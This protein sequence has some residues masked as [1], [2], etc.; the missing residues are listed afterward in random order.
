MALEI[1]GYE[2]LNK[3]GQGSMGSVFK[4]RQMSVDRLVAVKILHP[5]LAGNKDYL[6]RFRREAHLAARFSSIHVV[7][8]I[9]VGSAGNVHYFVMEYVE[10]KTVQADLSAGKVFGEREAL[11]IVLQVAQALRQAHRRGLVHRDVKPGNI[12]LTV[13]GVAKLADLGLARDTSDQAAVEA[14]QGSLV[15]TPYY[16]A[17]EQIEG[18]KDIDIRADL[19]ALGAT[20]Y[21]MVTGRPPFEGK[22]DEVLD[23]HLEQDVPHPDRINQTLSVGIGDAIKFMMAKDKAE[24]YR[25]PEELIIDLECLLNGEPPRLARQHLQA[26]VLAEL[27]E[28]EE[29]VEPGKESEPRKRKKKR[30]VAEEVDWWLQPVPMWWVLT[31]LGF[32]AFSLLLNLLLTIKIIMR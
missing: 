18:Q 31:A 14:E 22:V 23:S 28:G 3:L 26:A 25:T 8:A 7:Q 5:R 1:P 16:I 15:G 4:A 6:E 17:P 10:G 9:D 12:L 20:L 21:H 30:A 29:D 24:R 27:A 19:Y 2:I 32:L 13:D 11:T